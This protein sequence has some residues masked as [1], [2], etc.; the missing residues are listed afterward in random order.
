MTECS[1]IVALMVVGGLLELAGISL[2]I[3]QIR[4]DR[5]RA[6]RLMRRDQVVHLGG[7][8]SATAIGGVTVT[9]GAEPTLAERVTRLEAALLEIRAGLAETESKLR[10]ELREEIAGATGRVDAA[11]REQGQ[12]LRTF[13]SELLTGDLRRRWVGVVVLSGGIVLATA[14]NVWSLFVS[15]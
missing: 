4:G 10:A 5:E 12:E 1:S 9:G 15:C 6:R 14:A 11:L 8:A 7:V 2:L 3:L 13:L